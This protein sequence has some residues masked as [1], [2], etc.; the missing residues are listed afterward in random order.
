MC[1]SNA[2]RSAGSRSRSMKSYRGDGGIVALRGLPAGAGLK[3]PRAA[4]VEDRC[5]EHRGKSRAVSTA[6]MDR[7]GEQP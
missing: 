7:E 2:E 3:P 4:L 5:R 6:G 1:R